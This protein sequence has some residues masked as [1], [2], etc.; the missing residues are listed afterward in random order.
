[1]QQEYY[2]D[3]DYDPDEPDADDDCPACRGT[4]EGSFEGNLARCAGVGGIEM[5]PWEALGFTKEQWDAAKVMDD[6]RAYCAPNGLDALKLIKQL[7]L[8]APS[9]YEEKTK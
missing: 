8:N 3:H 2:D 5:E 9:Y 6:L 7:G 4:G 1:M